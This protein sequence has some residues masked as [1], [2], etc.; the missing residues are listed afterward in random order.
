MTAP[1][2]KIVPTR[3]DTF[4]RIDGGIIGRSAKGVILVEGDAKPVIYVPSADVA[5]V[6]LEPSEH[7]ETCPWKGEARYYNIVT[8]DR[9]I[10]NAAWRFDNPPPEAEAIRGLLTFDPRVVYVEVM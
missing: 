3:S 8:K 10:K 1:D 5:E 4:I 9:V 7:R 2:F 6:F